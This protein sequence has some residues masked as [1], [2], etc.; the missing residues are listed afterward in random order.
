MS[1]IIYP[2]DPTGRA[3]TNYIVEEQHVVTEANFSDYFFIVPKFAPFFTD[4]LVVK[5]HNLNDIRTLVEGSDYYLALNYLGATRSIGQPIYGAISFSSLINIGI[6]TISYQTL[7]G[8]W[9][10]DIEHVLEFLAEKHYNPRLV[11][12]DQVTNVQET[13]P[14]IN[15]TQDF[16]TLVGYEELIEAIV[17]ISETVAN[18]KDLAPTVQHIVNNNNPHNVTLE[19]LGYT[20]ATTEQALAGESNYSFITPYTL[21][22]VITYTVQGVDANIRTLEASVTSSLQ[23]INDHL[24]DFNNPH[25]VSKSQVGLAKVPNLELADDSEITNRDSVDKFITLRQV[26]NL[27]NSFD[28]TGNPTESLNYN[29]TPAN[30]II[31]EGNGVLFHVGT[32]DIPDNTVLYWSV[33]NITTTDN[34]FQ[35]TSGIITIQDNS[36][37]FVVNTKADILQESNELFSIRLRRDGIT[38]PIVATSP[39]IMIVDQ[40]V[41]NNFTILV[42]PNILDIGESTLVTVYSTAIPNGTLAYW[43]IATL[44]IDPSAFVATSGQLTFINNVASFTVTIKNNAIIRSRQYFKIQLRLDSISGSIVEETNTVTV[45]RLFSVLDALNAINIYDP[46]INVTAATFFVTNSYKPIFETR[47]ILSRR[48]ARRS[49]PFDLADSIN[50][51]N[52]FDP[53]HTLDAAKLF[54]YNSMY[55]EFNTRKLYNRELPPP[56]TVFP[57]LDALTKCNI[58]MPNVELTA[59]NFFT[60]NSCK[61]QHR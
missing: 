55:P 14:P 39:T 30:N 10:A 58:F 40:I 22:H 52:L 16:E 36:A 31:E 32:I 56:I 59:S 4:R 46:N 35:A 5:H 12:W 41:Q 7:G 38:G 19:Q 37:N 57:T 45:R 23:T 48:L 28:F 26:I 15:H 18:T 43:T 25:R 51:Y 21:S 9:C 29:I 60:I 27:L 49:K 50:S 6:V 17:G 11:V 13:F 20:V 3:S 61:T 8:P 54:V 44:T 47:S 33:A 24:R 42:E 53:N 34:D 2:F 1:E